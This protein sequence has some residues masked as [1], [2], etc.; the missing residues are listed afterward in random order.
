MLGGIIIFPYKTGALLSIVKENDSNSKDAYFAR[1][2]LEVVKYAF[3]GPESL[4]F[5]RDKSARRYHHFSLYKT[6]ALLSIVNENDS[7]SK[8]AYF[9]RSSLEVVKYAFLGRESLSFCRDKS[10]RRYHHFPLYNWSTF[11]PVTLPL[12]GES[13]DQQL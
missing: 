2:S 1:S 4:S 9:A 10:A 3:L 7:N 11:V 12:N 13:L 5:C 6:G 8:D